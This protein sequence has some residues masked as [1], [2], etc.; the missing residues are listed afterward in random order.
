MFGFGKKKQAPDLPVVILPAPNSPEL[1]QPAYDRIGWTDADL[2]AIA[3]LKNE[4]SHY[5]RGE[6]INEAAMVEPL[7]YTHQNIFSDDKEIRYDLTRPLRN[8][9]FGFVDYAY[10]HGRLSIPGRSYDNWCHYVAN[11]TLVH[12]KEFEDW[13]YDFYRSYFYNWLQSFGRYLDQNLIRLHTSMDVPKILLDNRVPPIEPSEEEKQPESMYNLAKKVIL[14]THPLT[15][16][17]LEGHKVDNRVMLIGYRH[18]HH[19][20]QLIT[21]DLFS[22]N[23]AIRS[24]GFVV[25]MQLEFVV[26]YEESCAGNHDGWRFGVARKMD[27]FGFEV[28]GTGRVESIVRGLRAVAREE[29]AE[30]EEKKGDVA[31]HVRDKFAKNADRYISGVS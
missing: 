22:G 28:K 21:A 27:E 26:A 15:R 8:I 3:V 12:R 24:I 14:T 7:K 9:T 30:M 2:K 10:R 5:K 29:E 31:K 20:S 4:T 6:F 1:M 18:P 13:E 23:S 17:G 16:P 11:R 25:G 19:S